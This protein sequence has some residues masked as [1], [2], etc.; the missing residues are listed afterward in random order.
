M[1]G[2]GLVPALPLPEAQ[3]GGVSGAE[4]L[5]GTP[6]LLIL[7]P[8]HQRRRDPENS[9]AGAVRLQGGSQGTW[10]RRGSCH[11]PNKAPPNACL[12]TTEIIFS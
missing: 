1:D 7:H 8:H 6:V 4:G 11:C 3:G 2:Q 12:R 10:L 9:S 5:V